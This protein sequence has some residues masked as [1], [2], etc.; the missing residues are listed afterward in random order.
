MQACDFAP[1]AVN[2]PPGDP[3][4]VV[5]PANRKKSATSP[6][7]RSLKHM[8]GLGYTCAI[9]EHW[10]PFA[11]IRQD[12]FGFIDVLCVKGEDIVGV[13]TTSGDHVAERVAKIVAHENW[14][15]VCNAITVIVHGWRKSAKGKWVLREVEL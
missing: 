4:A 14:P 3:H 1:G 2:L 15:L 13:Q 9:V 6:T 8:R 11:H 12:L 7:Q 10:N 5:I